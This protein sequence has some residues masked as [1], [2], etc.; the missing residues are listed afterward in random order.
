MKQILYLSCFLAVLS[1]CSRTEVEN[2]GLAPEG[3]DA[4][5]YQNVE[6]YLNVA[7]TPLEFG[8]PA[9]NQNWQ[10]TLG[11][12][13][14]Y[15]KNLSADGKISCASCHRQEL[16]FGDDKAFSEGVFGR[17]TDRNSIALAVFPFTPEFGVKE[18]ENPYDPDNTSVQGGL[19]WDNRAHNLTDQCRATLANEKEMD[20]EMEEVLA[21]MQRQPFYGWLFEKAFDTPKITE[22]GMIQGISMFLAGMKSNRS[23]FDLASND[24]DI[25]DGWV[26]PFPT[27]TAQE[28]RG[29]ELF[30][31]KC[32]SCH[33]TSLDRSAFTAADNGLEQGANPDP[34]LAKHTQNSSDFG[35]FKAPPLRNIAVTGPYMHDGRFRKLREVLNHYTRTMVGGR[36]IALTSDEK[37]DLVAFLFT[38]TDREF[39]FNP[40]FAFPKN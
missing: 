30:S 10:A 16:A 3:P 24:P 32:L 5:F 20:M 26:Q 35:V 38:L 40:D 15:D 11:K 21:A 27:F 36:Q 4:A 17:H 39:L 14:F 12:V 7:A 37:T 25:P 9:A 28:N 19:F 13:I 2:A 6:P 22:T 31:K 23:R 29:K 18:T 8:F 34:G 33:T 1:A